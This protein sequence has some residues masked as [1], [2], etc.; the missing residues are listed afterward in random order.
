M[1][2]QGEPQPHIENLILAG[3]V[4]HERNAVQRLSAIVGCTAGQVLQAAS[5]SAEY[6][7]FPIDAVLAP[8]R[9][10]G[11]GNSVDLGL[12]GHEGL[13]G[14]DSFTERRRQ[15]D[16]LVVRSGGTAYCMPAGDFRRQFDRRGG[17][18][19]A[20]LR[21][22]S[23]FMLQLGQNA[24]CSRFHPLEARIARW[25]LMIHDRGGV[26]IELSAASLA[27]SL[28]TEERFVVDAL[29]RLAASRAIRIRRHSLSVLEEETLEMRACDCYEELRQIY[30]DV[31]PS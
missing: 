30:E 13:I 9:R 20:V 4:V 3:L 15:I 25:L 24:V 10:I 23:A 2:I 11:G 22:S 18:H 14:C 21:F 8:V 28:G 1:S 17:L 7:F 27:C 12:V 6:I 29:E 16:D 5:G 26:E 19:G 31:M